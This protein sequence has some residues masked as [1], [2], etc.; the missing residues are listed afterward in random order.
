MSVY[1]RNSRMHILICRL[2]LT[3]ICILTAL[4]ELSCK[5]R[6]FQANLLAL[7]IRGADYHD[8][9][10]GVERVPTAVDCRISARVVV[11]DLG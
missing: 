9:E 1:P 6:S 10:I 7:A 5:R 11:L 2:L 4:P 8:F 3:L